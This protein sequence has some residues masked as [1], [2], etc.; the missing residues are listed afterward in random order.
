MSHALFVLGKK[1]F[2][3]S[4]V[5]LTETHVDSLWQQICSRRIIYRNLITRPPASWPGWSIRTISGTQRFVSAAASKRPDPLRPHNSGNVT[6]RDGT[7]Q[8]AQTRRNRGSQS[9]RVMRAFLYQHFEACAC[10][11]CGD[12]VE[13]ESVLIKLWIIVPMKCLLN[14]ISACLGHYIKLTWT[15]VTGTILYYTGQ[16][17][18][19]KE[20]IRCSVILCCQLLSHNH[21]PC[22]VLEKVNHVEHICMWTNKL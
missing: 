7:G 9:P 11:W 8:P 17:S 3:G 2:V 13:H 18:L 21:R 4:I 6:G 14:L 16:G 1:R 10:C 22:V 5:K 12:Q 19:A 20:H 15:S